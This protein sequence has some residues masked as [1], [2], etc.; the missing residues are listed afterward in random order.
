MNDLITVVVPI[1]NVEPY[2]HTCI[3]SIINQT[4]N[5]LEIILVAS[6]STDNS[7]AIAE[8]YAAHDS[9]ISVIHRPK[10][11]L[12]DGRNA[13]INVAKGTYICFVDSDDYIAP[14]YVARLHTLCTEYNAD[15]AQCSFQRFYSGEVTKSETHSKKRVMI[16]DG[17]SMCENLYNFYGY[18]S[19]V[20]WT[21]LYKRS[22]FDSIRYPVGELYE[23]TSTTYKLF[24]AAN[25]VVMIPEKL[26][27]YR[28]RDGSIMHTSW[29]EKNLIGLKVMED[30][31]EF[32]QDKQLPNLVSK[33]ICRCYEL[34]K[35]YYASALNSFPENEELHELLRTKFKYYNQLMKEDAYISFKDYWF[36]KL[37]TMMQ[38]RF[39]NLSERLVDTWA[40][41]NSHLSK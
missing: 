27:H 26:Y 14:D 38:I 37:T 33:T 17:I 31:L 39:P 10:L 21:K 4:Y 18:Y 3:D 2:L 16:F 35:R 23:D 32:F 40:D 15:I 1:Y 29:S 9:R 19:T 12:S 7:V 6:E 34:A 25:R 28:M 5:N 24:Y 30:R 13:G 8:E 11:G 22:L 41:V 36:T 20:A